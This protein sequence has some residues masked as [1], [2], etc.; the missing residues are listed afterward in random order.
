MNSDDLKINRYAN[1]TDT[2]KRFKLI[3][4]LIP[5]SADSILDVGCA[6]YDSNTRKENDLHKLLLENTSASIKGIDI[7]GDAVKEMRERGY[8]VTVANAQ[9]FELNISFDLIIA[10]EIIEYLSNPG[11]FIDS[12]LNHLNEGGSIIFTTENPY[13]FSFWRK[14]LH[15]DYQANTIWI[16]PFNVHKLSDKINQED[17]EIKWISPDGGISSL[18]WKLGFEISS[19][20]RYC[21][22]ITK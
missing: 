13:A 2:R 22:I 17:I 20:P 4:E 3:Y 1:R 15:S 11:M 16:D 8:D 18:L 12:G 10:G 19:A 7:N 6:R 5:E 9:D 21:T 14:S